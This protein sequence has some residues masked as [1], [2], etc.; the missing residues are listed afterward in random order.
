MMSLFDPGPRVSTATAV[1]K[2]A[3]IGLGHECLSAHDGNQ[4][5]DIA[6]K[7]HPDLVISDLMMPGKTGLE[8]LATEGPMPGIEV[9]RSRDGIA[10]PAL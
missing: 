9:R 7:Q 10:R 1:T 8:V 6:R 3:V 5:L 2:A 4:A